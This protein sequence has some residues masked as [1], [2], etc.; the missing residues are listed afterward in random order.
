MNIRQV[1]AS[2]YPDF[3]MKGV[4]ED[5]VK[6]GGP[7]IKLEKNHLICPSNAMWVAIINKHPR[8][9]MGHEGA[10]FTQGIHEYCRRYP[11]TMLIQD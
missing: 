1:R 10:Q 7:G 2:Y 4:W 9:A 11:L 3:D 8:L 5:I 6:M